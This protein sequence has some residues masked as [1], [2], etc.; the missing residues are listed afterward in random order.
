MR[1]AAPF[2]FRAEAGAWKYVCD[3]ASIPNALYMNG[4][5]FRYISRMS[6]LSYIASMRSAV[7]HSLTF[8]VTTQSL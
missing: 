4:T 5:V 6:S 8:L 7:I 2:G 1:V 3:A